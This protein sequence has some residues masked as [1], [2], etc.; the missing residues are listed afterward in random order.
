MEFPFFFLFPKLT[1]SFVKF[2]R[3]KLS[4]HNLR[5]VMSNPNLLQGKALGVIIILQTNHPVT[6]TA[7]F[8]DGLITLA[9]AASAANEVG[10][11]HNDNQTSQG[12]TNGDWHNAVRFIISRAFRHIV[13][14]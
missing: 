14:K 4:L 1:F 7:R 11:E 6:V 5:L 2:H 8:L 9:T 3:K 13:S 12:C 10:N